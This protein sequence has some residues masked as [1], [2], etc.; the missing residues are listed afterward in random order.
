MCTVNFTS[1]W[2]TDS[3]DFWLLEEQSSPKWE[4]HCL[5]RRW[6]AMQNWTPL[7]LSLAKKYVTVQTNKQTNKYV[8]LRGLPYIHTCR[9]YVHTPRE[10]DRHAI[11][12]RLPTL[13]FTSGW[14]ADWSNFGLLGSG[15]QSSNK[16]EIPCIGG[17]WTTV[18]NLTPLA[19]S[20]P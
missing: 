11:T 6:T 1:E 13:N 16:W 2:L 3:S 17:P 20:S 8:C 14:V 18:Q 12:V 7:A 5:W 9:S 4:I 10:I 19:L 15:E